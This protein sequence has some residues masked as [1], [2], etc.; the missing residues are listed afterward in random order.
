MAGLRAFLI[1]I[2]TFCF[3]LNVPPMLW[4]INSRNVPA[5]ALLVYLEIW[6]IQGL[7]GTIIWG[8]DNFVDN[9]DGRGWCD[10]IVRVQIMAQI[11]I[12]GAIFCISLNLL[13]ILMAN[14][15]TE[16]WFSRWKTKM[17]F[18]LFCVLGFPVLVAAFVYFGMMFRYGITQCAGCRLMMA[19]YGISVLL[20][21]FWL[22][23]WA[24]LGFITAAG[25]LVVFFVKRTNTRNI[26][27]CTN[28]GYSLRKFNKLLL[29]SVL[30]IAAMFPLKLVSLI[31]MV[32]DMKPGFKP[33]FAKNLYWDII[34][35]IPYKAS[36]DAERWILISVSIVSFCLFGLG[37]DAVQMYVGWVESVPAGRKMT[38][39][40]RNWRDSRHVAKQQNYLTRHASERTLESPISK[41]YSQKSPV[42]SWEMDEVKSYGRS[43]DT[44]SISMDN[45]QATTPKDEDIRRELR[46]AELDLLDQD[47]RRDLHRMGL[48]YS[49][50]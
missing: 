2:Q 4:H 37:E 3:V 43:V 34:L 36:Q 31:L 13:L 15:W 20:Y 6:M 14:K 39:T 30:V 47:I 5:S 40:Y 38:K 33:D 29:F 48:N 11:G 42:S 12:P 24:V 22:F 7:V 10:L 45:S 49:D 19:N 16:M 44:A 25:T 26:L 9:W 50:I 41:E 18:E 46:Q 21:Y 35:R 28:S 27:Q 1:F 8:G 23:F 32:R 17:A